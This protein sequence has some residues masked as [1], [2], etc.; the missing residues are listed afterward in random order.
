M[1]DSLEEAED[2][3]DMQGALKPYCLSIESMLQHD[4]YSNIEKQN[5]RELQKM[6]SELSIHLKQLQEWETLTKSNIN[7]YDKNSLSL[8]QESELWSKTEKN[9]LK[10][11]APKTLI[12]HIESVNKDI[13]NLRD[14]VK[15][16]YDKSLINSQL[17]TGK[18]LNLQEIKE[19]LKKT[20]TDVTNKVFHQNQEPFFS[21][22]MK[23]KLNL[24]EYVE[25]AG[26]DKYAIINALNS[27]MKDFEDAVQAETA[28]E[29]SIKTVITRNEK[30]FEKSDL[31]IYN[32]TEFI[33]FIK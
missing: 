27:E 18:I 26:V 14:I 22:E 25:I 31:D 29:H 5:V 15:K 4:N 17:I 32:P 10:E 16:K 24:F 11:N 1:K 2:V 33:Q 6:G 7:K 30:D 21:I 23:S 20:E 13:S 19:L 12:K 3:K 9:A 8:K 28:K